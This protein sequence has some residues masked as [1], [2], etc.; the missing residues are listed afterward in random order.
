MWE[1][2]IL[3]HTTYQTLYG[4]VLAAP[5]LMDAVLKL[6][7]RGSIGNYQRVWVMILKCISAKMKFIAMK[8]LLLRK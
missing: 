8:I 5:T 3:L 2:G 4:T 6:V 1:P 7:C